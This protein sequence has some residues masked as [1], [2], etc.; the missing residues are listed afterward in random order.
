[1][2]WKDVKGMKKI[3]E[4]KWDEL[5][6]YL[7]EHKIIKSGTQLILVSLLILGSV[8][9]M[10][11]MPG[12]SKAFGSFAK[13]KNYQRD[14]I[15]RL[16]RK[17]FVK[18][19][20]LSNGK[21]EISI[22]QD[23]CI[24]ILKYNLG[25]MQLIH[26]KKWDKKWRLILFDIPEKRKVLRDALRKKIKELGLLKIQQSVYVY[27]YQCEKEMEFLVSYFKIRPFVKYFTIERF[28]GD[29]EYEKHFKV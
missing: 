29:D 9:L 23:G 18:I 28:E 12:L 26:R 10:V 22:T 25:T 5:W 14:V 3:L 16:E 17:G 13:S 4:R 27:P 20:H 1:M 6:D 21:T 11:L 7:E 19:R 2:R 8:P 15:K 24:K